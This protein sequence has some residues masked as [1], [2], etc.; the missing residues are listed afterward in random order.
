ME[1]LADQQESLRSRKEGLAC[2]RDVLVGRVLGQN[3]KGRIDLAEVILHSDE[4]ERGG[5]ENDR[6]CTL[7]C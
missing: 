1:S 2:A 7:D 3:R 4:V 5:D 6:V